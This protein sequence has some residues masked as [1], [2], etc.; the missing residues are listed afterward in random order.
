MV[1]ALEARGLG[2]SFRQS[3]HAGPRTFRQ[4]V[5]GGFARRRPK[6]RFWALRGVDF[7]VAQGEMT[8][9]IGHN[10]S[11]KST[12]LRLLGGVMQPDEGQVTTTGPV[13]GLLELNT[14][15]HPDLSGRENI[16]INGVL[17]GMLRSE[18]TARTDDI[19]AFAELADH[20][21]QPVRTYSS[22]MKLRLGFSIA[23]HVDPKILLIDE[24][25]AVGDMAFQQKCLARIGAFKDN[26]CAIVLITHDMQHVR[27]FC[28]KVIWMDHGK[29]RAI[30][31]PDE[32]VT[33]YETAMRTETLKRS[34]TARA[35]VV[36]DRG[37]RLRMDENRFGSGDVTLVDVTLLDDQGRPVAALAPGAPMTVRGTM[38]AAA[39]I[40]ACHVSISIVDD[41]GTLCLDVNTDTDRITMPAFDGTLPVTL[42]LGRLDLAPGRYRVSMGV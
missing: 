12:L 27:N 31:S 13:N 21:D 38:H 26:G 39:A 34:D 14:G 11:G 17:G 32:V 16:V 42:T 9:V 19:I 36:T 15:M 37:I 2:K 30:G 6:D 1:V 41:E 25:L 8:G 28:E 10:G 18:M 23:V 35:D 20:I 24:V 4:W 22:G 7:A 5:E 29:V 40:N 33:L 3:A